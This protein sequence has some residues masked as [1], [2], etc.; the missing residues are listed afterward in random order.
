MANHDR[1]QMLTDFRV[2]IITLAAIVFLI[3][4][5]LFAG[6][7]KGL[8]FRKTSVVKARLADV[9]GLKKGGS[10]T[11]GGMIIGKVT[12]IQ[13][14]DHSNAPDDEK[15]P[16]QVTMEI[17]SDMRNRIGTRTIPAVRTQGMLGDRYIDLPPA[18]N[19][20]PPLPEGQVLIGEQTTDFDKTLAEA[21]EVLNETHKVLSAVNEQRGTVGQLVHD[22]EFYRRLVD[23]VTELKDLI[24]DFKKNPKKYIDLSVF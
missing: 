21:I 4:G 3:L 20:D 1:K 16:I 22:E 24:Q 18:R 2:G 19:G 17:R 5:I 23:V 7:D 9:G 6:G 12:D 15:N 10:V 13:Y 14:I 8:V 11:M